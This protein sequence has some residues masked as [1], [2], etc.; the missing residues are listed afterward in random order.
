MAQTQLTSR[1]PSPSEVPGGT[2][3]QNPASL[4]GVIADPT[5]A[6]IPNA[7]VVVTA[8]DGNRVSTTTD[9]V[10]RYI[11][12]TLPPG[13]YSI[14]AS[15]PGFA[16]AIRDKVVLT[17]GQKATTDLQLI[18]EAQSQEVHVGATQ[19]EVTD[20]HSDGGALKLK[21]SSLSLLSSDPNQMLLQL[22][23]MAG[24]DG[25]SAG[26]LYINGF[27]GG[28]MPPRA[29]IREIRINN[30]PYS[31][32][33]D[34]Y[35]YGRIEIFTKPGTDSLHGDFLE[36]G[37]NASFDARNPFAPVKPDFYST[38]AQGDISGP[39]TKK[40][41]YFFSG[42]LNKSQNSFVVDAETLD[43]NNQQ[44]GL[45][46]TVGNPTTS[47]SISPR[48][49]A[50]LSTGNTLSM[51]YDFT[52]TTAGNAGVGQLQLASQGYK[53]STGVGTLQVSDTQT[54]GVKFVNELRFQYIRTRTS[55]IPVD[56]SP[57]LIVEGAFTGGGNN[58]G[59]FTDNQDQYEIQN[60]STLDLGKHFLRFGARERLN[61]D[62]NSS[63]ANFNGEYIFSTLN[64]YQLT[65]QGLKA[66]LTPAQIRASGGGASQFNI[67]TGVPSV[68]VLI[69]DTGVYAEDSWKI[70]PNFSVACGGRFET[71]NYIADH[72]DF[73]PRFSLSYGIH[74]TEKKP[75]AT[76]LSAGFGLFYDRFPAAD[77]LTAT[78]QNGIL[79]RQYVLNSPDT[80]PGIPPIDELTSTTTATTFQL[81]PNYRSPYIMRTGISLN[82]RF[83]ERLNL[84]LGYSNTRGV[85]RLL[86]RNI[87]A[88]LPGTYD[89]ANPSSGDRPLG[90]IRNVYEYDTQG[91]SRRNRV[92]LNGHYEIGEKLQ[93]FGYYSIGVSHSDTNGG[94]PSNQYNIAADYGRATNDIRQR[95]F[96]GFFFNFFHGINGGPFLRAQTGSPFDIVVGQDLNGDG[97]F[98]DRPTFATDLSRPSVIRTRYGNFDTLPIA[99]QRIIPHNYGNGPGLLALNLNLGKSFHFGPEAKPDP[100]APKPKPGTTPPPPERRYTL[101]SGIEID[102]ILNHVNPAVPVGT[103]G[104]P[105]FGLS[106]ALSQDSDD[107]YSSANR[108]I[109]LQI[110]LR[111]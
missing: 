4:S 57:T 82:R 100:D 101:S 64:A 28:R 71:Q 94:F 23:G 89:P 58:L 33:Y 35:G 46:Q 87:N 39:I 26:A 43:A 83:S 48:L 12:S 34:D 96:L 103:L 37:N 61:R 104:S 86:T 54:A 108:S 80:Y 53:S 38:Y 70:R 3:A 93:I 1:R 98:N 16:S 72:A 29:S 55:Q 8:A 78:R 50:Q 20:A 91:L 9:G 21:G 81:S 40:M 45:T 67:T 88:P 105:L 44:V 60:Y 52:R 99:G 74:G 63:T 107:P 5:G 49:D 19:E 66:G 10:G 56:S 36:S 77:I 75:A 79:Q 11:I 62:A 17:P 95:L 65:Q 68:A 18:I 32:Q 90:G 106:N 7:V 22:Q 25:D 30:D 15:A 73:S 6:V 110:F 102:N 2:A 42:S 69:S 92:Y 31:A 41:S 76:T 51:N 111:F 47:F 97:Q 84:S 109:N 14:T 59:R 13:T 85:H 24:G 27:S